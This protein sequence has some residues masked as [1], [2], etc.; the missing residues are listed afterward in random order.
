MSKELKP[1]PCDPATK[2]LMEESCYGCET[3]SNWYDHHPNGPIEDALYLSNKLMT[4]AARCDHDEINKLRAELDEIKEQTARII[5]DDHAKDEVHCG[6]CVVLRAEL[7]QAM[8]E[9]D[10]AEARERELRDMQREHETVT[11]GTCKWCA[12]V[13]KEC[14]DEVEDVLSS[15][16]QWGIES[17]GFD[18]IVARETTVK[19]RAIVRERDVHHWGQV[20]GEVRRERDALRAELEQAQALLRRCATFINDYSGGRKLDALQRDVAKHAEDKIC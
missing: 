4:E 9:R 6:C 18:A 14:I 10:E 13:A 3:Y 16:L 17:E 11:E 1:C 5:A 19:A 7:E 20:A 12:S 8:A 15:A 2:C